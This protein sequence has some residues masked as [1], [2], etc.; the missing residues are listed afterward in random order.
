MRHQ[1][2]KGRQFGRKKGVREA[3]LQSLAVSLIMN[4]KI[5]TTEARAKEL[6]RVIEPYVTQARK[7]SVAA[8]RELA[9]NLPPKAVKKLVDEIAPRY[10]SRPGGYTR[11]TKMMIRK[12]DAAPISQ[13]E[14]V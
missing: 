13:I 8:R 12:K 9:K 3:F 5:A 2:K 4:E 11:I 10:K 1:N 14:F 6:S 7:G